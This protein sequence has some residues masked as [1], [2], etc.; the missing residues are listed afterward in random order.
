MIIGN[1]AK[2]VATVL[3][4]G[5]S[6]GS[7]PAPSKSIAAW[8]W[9]HIWFVYSL[10]AMGLL[11][12][13]LGFLFSNG[14]IPAELA[15]D[16]SLVLKV[17]LFGFLWGVGSLLFGVS[18]PRLGMAITNALV[19]GIVAFLGSLGPLLLGSV[20]LRFERLVWLTGG[21]TLLILSLILCAA[22]SVTR[23]HAQR[24]VSRASGSRSQSIGAVLVATMAGIMSAML[25]IG[26]VLGAPLSHRAV[27]AGCPSSLATV[28]IWVPALLGGL[29][30]N[31]GYPVWK[32][33][34]RGSWATLFCGRNMA[35]PWIRS[36][37]MGVLWFGAIL[38]YGIGA[39]LMGNDGA[40]YGWVLIV[41][42]SILASNGWGVVTG[43]WKDCGV[44]PKALMS[45]STG[46]LILSLILLAA[47][48]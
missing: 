14:S 12:V 9:E 5:V 29:V 45:V 46:L 41:A 32:I 34:A 10:W 18:L 16:P 47:K 44:K 38:L 1:S 7:F 33:F 40:V 31:M 26:F 3:A 8:Q 37:F 6:N 35:S 39:S 20:Q 36:S 27:Q 22:A 11:P 19:N 21:L 30:F 25:N 13:G 24:A 28:A 17:A 42:V 2:G 23:D 15:R 43:E 48:S 4:A